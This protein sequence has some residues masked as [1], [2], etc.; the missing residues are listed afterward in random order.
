MGYLLA[1]L[2]KGE[3]VSPPSPLLQQVIVVLLTA[4]AGCTLFVAV[5]LAFPRRADD[6][7][8]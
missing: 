4:G 7:R 6:L 2:A 5:R 1:F 8:Q 3:Y